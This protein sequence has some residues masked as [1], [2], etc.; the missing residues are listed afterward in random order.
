MRDAASSG[1]FR[2]MRG[3]TERAYQVLWENAMKFRQWMLC[4]CVLHC[5]LYVSETAYAETL[6]DWIVVG[7]PGNPENT[8]IKTDGTSGF[9]VR[10]IIHSN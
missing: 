5:T 3:F 6:M 7:D 8:I 2:V 10:W 4:V 1:I 9:V